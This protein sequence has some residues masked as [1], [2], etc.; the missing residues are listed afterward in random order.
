MART[1]GDGARLRQFPGSGLPMAALR[2]RVSDG[3]RGS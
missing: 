2:G 3:K 1:R